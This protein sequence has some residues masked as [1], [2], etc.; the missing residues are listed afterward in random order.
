MPVIQEDGTT[1]YPEANIMKEVSTDMLEQS[2]IR[3][4][5]LSDAYRVSESIDTLKQ[6]QDIVDEID[7]PFLIWM[8]GPDGRGIPNYILPPRLR[9]LPEEILYLRLQAFTPL[10]E[11]NV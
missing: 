4:L 5:E 11:G 6:I 8:I 2:R 10:R 7:R 1:D 9:A 3:L